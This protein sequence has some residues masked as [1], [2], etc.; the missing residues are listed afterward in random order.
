M[1]HFPR[2]IV[3][4]L[5]SLFNSIAARNEE[6]KNKASASKQLEKAGYVP[7]N[8]QVA[9]SGLTSANMTGK[10]KTAKD[11]ELDEESAAGLRKVQENDAQINAGLSA[12][13]G[14]LDRLNLLAGAMRDEV[15]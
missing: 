12:I 11:Q 8:K 14:Q 13:D 6:R 9:A 4:F 15:I 1:S 7:R 2:C 3:V 10:G 5:L